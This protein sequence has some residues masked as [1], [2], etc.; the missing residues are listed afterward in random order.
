MDIRPIIEDLEYLKHVYGDCPAEEAK[1][2]EQYPLGL[3]GG[4]KE[5]KK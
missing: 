3:D 2:Y 4:L 5:E 1:H